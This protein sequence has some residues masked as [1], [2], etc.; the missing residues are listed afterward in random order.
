MRYINY[1]VDAKADYKQLT[2]WSFMCMH[3]TNFIKLKQND[4]NYE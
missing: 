3:V 1:N 2:Y 4:D